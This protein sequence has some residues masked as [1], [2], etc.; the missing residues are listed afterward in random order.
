MPSA[1]LVNGVATQFVPVNDRGLSYGDGVYETILVRNSFPEFLP[2]HLQ[3]LQ[4]ACKRLALSCDMDVL[5]QE[6]SDLIK[7]SSESLQLKSV[8]KIILTR[9]PSARGYKIYPGLKTT[10]I[11]SLDTAPLYDFDPRD[12]VSVCLCNT[13]ISINPALAGIKHLSRLENVLARNEWRDS[14]IAEGLMMDEAG[15]LVEGTMSN[16]F[17][18]HQGRLKTPALSR[19]GVEGVMRKVVIEHLAPLLSIPVDICDMNV[20]DLVNAESAFITN[21]LIGIWPVT[22]IGC[23][24]KDIDEKLVALQLA[25]ENLQGV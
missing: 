2:Q 18:L 12:G 20:N 4:T 24:R 14:K 19:C 17:L 7:Q 21:S 3:R 11:V 16:I 15:H 6:I 1:V 9:G 8:I 13:S 25:L 23:H 10:R 22:S 5:S